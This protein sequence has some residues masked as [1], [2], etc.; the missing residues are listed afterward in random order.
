MQAYHLD[1]P[2]P[3]SLQGRWRS[4]CSADKEGSSKLYDLRQ[5]YVSRQP[6]TQRQEEQQLQQSAPL[7]LEYEAKPLHLE[8]ADA[9]HTFSTSSPTSPWDHTVGRSR[10]PSPLAAFGVTVD[11]Q[12]PEHKFVSSDTIGNEDEYSK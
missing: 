8:V 6:I 2:R 4:R 9:D 7:D 11:T 10:S 3:P 5:K 12:L 1:V